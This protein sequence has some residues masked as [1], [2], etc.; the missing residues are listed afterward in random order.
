M[1]KAYNKFQQNFDIQD[2]P[3]KDKMIK[4]VTSAACTFFTGYAIR[5][6]DTVKGKT[7]KRAK[8][9][10]GLEQLQHFGGSESMLDAVLKTQIDKSL[11]V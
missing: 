1:L 6:I 11:R 10:Q 7:E 2:G 4:T 3:L 5:I 8:L 9:Q